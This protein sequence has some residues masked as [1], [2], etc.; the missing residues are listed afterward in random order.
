MACLPELARGVL[1]RDHDPSVGAAAADVAAQGTDD[2]F[3]PGIGIGLEQGQARHDHAGGAVAALHG[4]GFDER[5]LQR[6]QPAV[7]LQTFDRLDCLV[8]RDA[9]LRDARPDRLAVN[10]H[11]AGTALAFA[12]A[13]LAAGQIQVAAEHVEKASL[14]V[15]MKRASSTIHL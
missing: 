9:H 7:S 12:A 11:G 13:V 8:G 5:L 6:M 4:I 10:E 3:V 14:R 1:H 15:G 2:V